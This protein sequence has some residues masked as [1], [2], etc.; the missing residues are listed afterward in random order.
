MRANIMRSRALAGRVR[1]YHTWPVLH[2]ETVAEHTF[3]VLRIYREI[4]GLR[5]APVEYIMDHDL[6]ELHVGDMPFPLK[7]RYPEIKAAL[8]TAERDARERL[9]LPTDYAISETDR[10]RVKVCDL[11]QMWE[12]GKIEVRLG[13]VMATDIVSDTVRAATEL[14]KLRLGD[15]DQDAIM[16]WLQNHVL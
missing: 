15:D 14:A 7:S 16:A 4:F 10:A 9:G 12:F 1:R 11:L 5:D 6:D 3:G 8:V 13:N 2:Q